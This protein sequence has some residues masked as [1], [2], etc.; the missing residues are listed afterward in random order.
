MEHAT[1]IVEPA[2]LYIG[3][4]ASNELLIFHLIAQLA[5]G[6]WCGRRTTVITHI[7]WLTAFMIVFGLNVL[8][9]IFVFYHFCEL[10]LCGI[11]A[12]GKAHAIN[13]GSRKTIK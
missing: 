11:E 4:I 3:V 13:D 7:I 9:I 6:N 10:R 12:T 2:R 5:R 1:K 8:F